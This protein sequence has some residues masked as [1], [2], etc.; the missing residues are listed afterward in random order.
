MSMPAPNY[1]YSLSFRALSWVLSSQPQVEVASYVLVFL[2]VI[3]PT[4]PDL[5]PTK[6]IKPSHALHSLLL[7]RP[8]PPLRHPNSNLTL[9]RTTY[10]AIDDQQQH[11]SPPLLSRGHPPRARARRTQVSPLPI[12]ISRR[13]WVDL[14]P[15]AAADKPL[16]TPV[17]G[18]VEPLLPDESC[19]HLQLSIFGCG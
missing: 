14:V 13:L 8:P 16:S 11:D 4:R 7:S 17:I 1:L 5:S 3:R 18:S 2:P 9:P 19:M 10:H 15:N 6:R 12:S